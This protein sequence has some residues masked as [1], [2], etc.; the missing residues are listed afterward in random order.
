MKLFKEFFVVT[1]LDLL[2]LKLL[3]VK[4]LTKGFWHKKM[5]I[6]LNKPT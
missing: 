3:S 6:T 4:I 2:H 5:I 1:V